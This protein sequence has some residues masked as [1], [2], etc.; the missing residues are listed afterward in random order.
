MKRCIFSRNAFCSVHKENTMKM[1]NILLVVLLFFIASIS[2]AYTNDEIS[3][4][5]TS[6]VIYIQDN[7]I[8]YM[9]EITVEAWVKVNSFSATKNGGNEIWQFIIFKKNVLEH[10]NE[11]FAIY[12]DEKNR[13]FAA[14]VASAEGIQA[15]VVN[16]K[17]SVE[18]NSWYHVA[19]TANSKEIKLFVNGT[20]VKSASTGFPLNFGN[21]EVFIGGRTKI[22]KDKDFE[23]R[24]CGSIKNV[25]I[26]N[27]VLDNKEIMNSDD[28]SKDLVISGEIT[29]ENN[30]LRFVEKNSKEIQSEAIEINQDFTAEIVPNP[31]HSEA[32]LN[33]NLKKSGTIS[34][35][36]YDITGKERFILFEG[37]SEKGEYSY[38]ISN[39]LVQ[40]TNSSYFCKIDFEGNSKVIKFIILK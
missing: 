6:D 22:L 8:S 31:V 15:V 14:S 26:W 36:I 19:M 34:L 18:L 23:G 13:R 2:K 4:D 24:F 3:F 17:A 12:F 16:Q 9:T 33:L 11:G 38:N 7:S 10:Y 28:F 27:R 29:R 39:L 25:K 35:K 21:E 5:G 32:K 37:F 30:L 40:E 20:L 1:K